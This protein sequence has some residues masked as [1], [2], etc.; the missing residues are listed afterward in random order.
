MVDRSPDETQGT[1]MLH[2]SGYA[3]HG[4]IFLVRP[5][6]VPTL[7]EVGNEAVVILEFF[8]QPGLFEVVLGMRTIGGGCIAPLSHFKS[9]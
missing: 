3:W 6:V 1:A 9:A 2:T 7:Q 4:H 8:G 5:G